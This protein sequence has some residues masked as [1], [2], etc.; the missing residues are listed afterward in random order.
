ML[1]NKIITRGHY[2]Q[3]KKNIKIIKFLKKNKKSLNSFNLSS[4]L[5]FSNCSV[6]KLERKMKCRSTTAA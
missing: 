6:K 2:N 3:I 4:S 1:K 5:D